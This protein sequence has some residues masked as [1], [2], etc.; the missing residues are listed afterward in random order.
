MSVE[1]KEYYKNPDG[2]CKCLKIE[3]STFK[4]KAHGS[5]TEYYEN[6]KI[7]MI[8]NYQ[9]GILHGPVVSYYESGH[10]S[11]EMTLQNNKRNGIYKDYYP[12]GSLKI[13]VNYVNEKREGIYKDYYP[14][15]ENGVGKLKVIVNC[16]NGFF[17]GIYKSYYD[18]LEGTEA[19]QDENGI[20]GV[21]KE[22][23]NDY[24]GKI[25]G[26]LKRYFPNGKLKEQIIMN[27]GIPRGISKI[28]NS[29]GEIIETKNYG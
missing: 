8:Q 6:G 25:H 23:C 28:Y 12:N 2:S 4:G 16:V 7:K 9:H 3:Y 15:P 1:V 24:Q 20:H 29:D 21:L 22:E 19:I 11:I 18:V 26:I 14:G 17:H 10:L 5:Y 13:I 27:Y